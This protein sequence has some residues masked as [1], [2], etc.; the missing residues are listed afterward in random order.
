[1]VH[2]SWASSTDSTTILQMVVESVLF[3]ELFCYDMLNLSF[4]AM[5]CWSNWWFQPPWKIWKSDWIIIPTIGEVIKFH[6]SKPPT[7]DGWEAMIWILPWHSLANSTQEAHDIPVILI[8]GTSN[9]AIDNGNP[10]FVDDVFISCF[11]AAFH[12]YH[13]ISRGYI[14]DFLRTPNR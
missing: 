8:V 5:I 10:S 14:L 4:S 12:G 6:G 2:H 7:S 1:M 13:P 11:N 9:R 3:S